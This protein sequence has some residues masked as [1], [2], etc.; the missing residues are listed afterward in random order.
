MQITNRPLIKTLFRTTLKKLTKSQLVTTHKTFEEY[1]TLATNIV[2]KL[3]N[4]KKQGTL[5]TLKDSESLI[6]SGLEAVQE[7]LKLLPTNIDEKKLDV[8]AG[9]VDLRQNLLFFQHLLGLENAKLAK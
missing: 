4:R 1:S 8:R 6:T 2:N 9:I 3:I 5:L 7:A